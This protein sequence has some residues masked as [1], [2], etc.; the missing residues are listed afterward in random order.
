M[1]DMSATVIHFW[2]RPTSVTTIFH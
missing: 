1:L 2:S